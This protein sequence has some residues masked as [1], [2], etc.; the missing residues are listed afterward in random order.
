MSDRADQAIAFRE[1]RQKQQKDER[2]CVL[3]NA[4]PDALAS[5]L[6]FKRIMHTKT[7]SAD[8]ARINEVT[9][10]DNLAMVRY[11]RIPVKNWL[12]EKAP[13]WNRFALVDSQPAHNP[14]FHSLKFDVIIDHHPLT[15][16]EGSLTEGAFCCIR[17]GIGATSTIMSQFLQV[18]RVRPGPLLATALLFGIRTDTGAFE[19]SGVEEDLRAYQWLSHHA[20]INLLRR[21][22]RSEYLRSW[23][24]FFSRAFRTL[25]D[26]PGQ[27]AFASL[28]DIP[29]A[30]LLVSVAD[31]FTKVHGLKW[32]AVGGVLAK[33][34][35]VVFRGDG[36]RDIGRFAD[37]CFYDVGTAGGHRNMGRAEFPLCAVPQGMKASEFVLKRLLT[38]KL[39]PESKR[40]CGEKCRECQIGIKEEINPPVN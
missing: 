25:V 10:P 31:F 37:A 35:I 32:I 19:R 28:N 13:F 15:N 8:I 36:S 23:L 12:P 5:A 1:W 3:I 14:A 11:L 33:T 39:R 18:M 6:A 7:Q 34:V 26:C 29:T 4:D 9:R 27:G 24:P 22:S 30:D 21:I 17:P 40:T 38:R 2:W 16:L 20:D